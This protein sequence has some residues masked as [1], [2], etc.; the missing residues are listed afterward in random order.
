MKFHFKKKIYGYECDV[1][2]HLNN[3]NY[4]QVYEAARAEALE[5]ADFP[6]RRLR[7]I[8]YSIYLTRI[9]LDYKKGVQLEDTIEVHTEIIENN[10]LGSVW[11]QTIYDSAGDLCNIAIIKGVFVKDFKPCRITQAIKEHFDR[12]ME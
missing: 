8:G 9:E 4:L 10:R 2:G 1:Y 7:E 5:Q 11:K 6:I 3:A 12:F